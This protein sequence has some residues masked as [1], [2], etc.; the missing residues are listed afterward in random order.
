MEGWLRH[1][2]GTTAL[3][4]SASAAG[5]AELVALL[6]RIG[7]LVQEADTGV[8]AL[9]LAQMA[10]PDV[11]ALDVELPGVS[12]Y[13][14]CYELRA[15]RG[16]DLAV[17]L[18]SAT[19]LTSL[20][21]T[22][23]FLIGADEYVTRPFESD[24]LLLRIRSLL[25]R[26]GQRA[27]HRASGSGMATLTPREREVLTLLAHGRNQQEIA[28]QLV[29]TPKTVAT[30]LQRVLSKLGVHSRAQAVAYAHRHGLVDA[31]QAPE[32]VDNRLVEAIGAHD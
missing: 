28:R 14:V 31:I 27:S 6:E 5:R 10:R 3:V 23:A 19:R 25:R 32:R 11:C 1:F 29:V 24:E 18:L 16:G 7:C 21:R 17:I 20:D 2:E 8:E 12:G 15:Q 30:H 26:H 4:A 9:T 22:A 13:E